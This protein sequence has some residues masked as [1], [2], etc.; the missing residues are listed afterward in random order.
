MDQLDTTAAT[1]EP[2]DSL[3]PYAGNPRKHD[4]DVPELA[5]GIIRLGW[6]APIIARAANRMI[7]GGHGRRLAA[8]EVIARWTRATTRER[9]QW[10]PD[11]VRVAERREVPVRLRDLD[12]HDSYLLLVA[13][14]MIGERLSETDE[15]KLAALVKKLSLDGVE[16][17]GGTGLDQQ[18]IWVKARPILTRS[19]FMWQHEP[20]FYGWKQGSL[21]SKRPPLGGEN[22]TVWHIDQQGEFTDGHPTIKPL[23][24]FTRPIGYH[25]EPGE[26]VYEPFGGSGTC[27][28][29]AAKLGRRCYAM[30]LAPPFVDVIRRRWTAFAKSAGIDPGPGALG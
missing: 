6:G 21:P 27:L 3:V 7:V 23:E 28:I 22:T 25:T 17:M 9:A 8:L 26:L 29:A 13:D 20:A 2:L 24:I 5:T 12:E 1:W 4:A 10:N 30:E 14:N 15:E 19:H 18:I 11:A 16:I